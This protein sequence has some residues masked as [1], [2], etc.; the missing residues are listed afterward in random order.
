MVLD[1][2]LEKGSFRLAY[3][4]TDSLLVCMTAD[5]IDDLVVQEKRAEWDTSVKPVWFADNTPKGQKTP[6]FLKLG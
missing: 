2:Y 4:D 5:S 6:G 3:C 1:E